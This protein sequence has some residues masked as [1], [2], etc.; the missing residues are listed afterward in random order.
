MIKNTYPVFVQNLAGKNMS[1]LL[2]MA[3][4]SQQMNPSACKKET[5]K[6]RRRWSTV[7]SWEQECASSELLFKK[8]T[9]LTHN[10]CRKFDAGKKMG[11]EQEPTKCQ[12]APCDLH[13]QFRQHLANGS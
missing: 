6:A 13:L 10:L 3:H 4:V 8:Q 12:M 5:A 1:A 9:N 7:A 11:K 2:V